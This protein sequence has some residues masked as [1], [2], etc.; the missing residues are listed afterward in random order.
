[1][2]P[3]CLTQVTCTDQETAEV[4]DEPLKTLKS[5]RSSDALGWDMSKASV[6]F[7]WNIVPK[8]QGVIKLYDD[9]QV[10][11]HRTKPVAKPSKAQPAAH[12]SQAP[13]KQLV[14]EP[15]VESQAD[16]I[17][18]GL[19]AAFQGAA[20]A[21]AIAGILFCLMYSLIK[22]TSQEEEFWEPT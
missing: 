10:L 14:S 4:G 11:R 16:M 2:L 12:N 21:A 9:I 7:G 18:G 13:V 3:N 5:F 22:A 8:Q 20:V 1:M 15:K 6:F 17:R 19:I